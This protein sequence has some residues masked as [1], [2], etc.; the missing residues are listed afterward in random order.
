MKK[1][2]LMLGALLIAGASI[3]Y[4]G[5][6]KD[7]KACCKKGTA[8]KECCSKGEKKSCD[9]GSAKKEDT[10]TTEKKS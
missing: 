3:A 8:K 5:D 4:A 9:K 6:N 1:M 10:K 2:T 7:G